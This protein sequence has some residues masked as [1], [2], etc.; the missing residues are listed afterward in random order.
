MLTFFAVLHFV[1]CL[2]ELQP[3][4]QYRSPGIADVAQR[5]QRL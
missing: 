4:L 3:G 5:L 2:L 1:P